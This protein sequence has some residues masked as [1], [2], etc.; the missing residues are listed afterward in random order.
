MTM[1]KWE[2]QLERS[3]SV[4]GFKE[5]TSRLNK[6]GDEGWEA[7]GVSEYDQ[8]FTVLLKRQKIERQRVNVE[9]ESAAPKI[10]IGAPLGGM[11]A[12]GDQPN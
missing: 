8:D 7:I 3:G 2:Y 4:E 10:H 12:P 6:L 1:V 11:P 5:F 9:S